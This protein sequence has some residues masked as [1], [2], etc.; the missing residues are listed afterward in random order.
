MKTE[1]QGSPLLNPRLSPPSSLF[2]VAE[3]PFLRQSPTQLA[4]SPLTEKKEA[5]VPSLHWI[6]RW[7][8]MTSAFK[9]DD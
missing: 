7:W 8:M 4:Q 9:F 6:R 3:R 1:N 5:K 2:T